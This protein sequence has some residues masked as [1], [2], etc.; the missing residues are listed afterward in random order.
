VSNPVGYDRDITLPEGVDAEKI[1]ASYKNSV[2]EVTL[3]TKTKAKTNNLSGY[4]GGRKMIKSIL[5]PTDGSSSADKA[6]ELA[7]ELALL[8]HA[9]IEGLFVI[10]DLL[11]HTSVPTMTASAGAYLTPEL[12][13]IRTQSRE[14][15]GRI[16]A[17]YSDRCEALGVPF[18][19]RIEQ[20]EIPQ[21]ICEVARTVDLIVMGKHGRTPEQ[22]RKDIGG[23]ISVVIRNAIRPVIV[24][25]E[26]YEKIESA[27]VAYDGSRQASHALMM[28]TFVVTIRINLSVTS[29]VINSERQCQMRKNENE[30]TGKRENGI[31]FFIFIFSISLT[32]QLMT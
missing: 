23:V 29:T 22:S 27:I 5:T 32:S 25:P 13:N 17:E 8:A 14:K 6:M 3:T 30:K 1:K 26:S 4:K 7:L 2:L 21:T 9:D 24:V 12:I 10:N 31:L 19:G 18:T 20:G 15:A 11:L 16:L 28:A